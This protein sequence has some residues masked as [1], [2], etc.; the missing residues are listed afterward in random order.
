MYWECSTCIRFED[1]PFTQASTYTGLQ[2]QLSKEEYLVGLLKH[3]IHDGLAWRVVASQDEQTAAPPTPMHYRA[4]SWSWASTDD[5]IEFVSFRGS[6]L[7]SG[8]DFSARQRRFVSLSQQNRVRVCD[9]YVKNLGHNPLGE[10][11]VAAIELEGKIK[12]G[13]FIRRT[14]SPF[15]W[16]RDAVSE[17]DT[18]VFDSDDARRWSSNLPE[19]ITC[20]CID[21]WEPRGGW[22]ALAIEPLSPGAGFP[23]S[24]RPSVIPG[25]DKACKAYRRIGLVNCYGVEGSNFHWFKDCPWERLEL[26]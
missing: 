26:Y 17:E 6:P 8:T 1:F 22:V 16:V 23:R 18:A 20:L 3:A 7:R 14:S 2:G 24:G 9:T 5:P 11:T 13:T 4:P 10:I 25:P 15:L 12:L 21:Y 19:E